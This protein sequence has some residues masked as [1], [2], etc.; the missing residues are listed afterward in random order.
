MAMMLV[1]VTFSGYSARVQMAT[2]LYL[3]SFRQTMGGEASMGMYGVEPRDG[4]AIVPTKS[5]H[6]QI[7]RAVYVLLFG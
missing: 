1:S 7:Q 2:L 6:Y 4:T 5:M 3:S